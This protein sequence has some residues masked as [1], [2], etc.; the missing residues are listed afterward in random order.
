VEWKR[1]SSQWFE[2]SRYV[3]VQVCSA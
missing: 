2:M 3:H 1:S